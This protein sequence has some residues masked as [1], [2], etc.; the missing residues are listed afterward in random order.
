[1]PRERDPTSRSLGKGP[2]TRTDLLK[3][4]R[5]LQLPKPKWAPGKSIAAAL[6][7][8]KTTREIS[9][10]SLGAQ[11]LS[12]VLF[13]A[14]GV[15][16][17][18]GPFGSRGIT[19]ASASNSQEIDVYVALR[20]G[21]YL[22]DA[23]RH[24]LALVV[25]EDVRSLALGPRQPPISPHAP[26][27]LIFVVDIDK[28][29]HTSGFEE[30]GLHDPEIQKSYYFVDTGIIAGNVYLVA[31]AQGLACWFHNCDRVSLAQKLTLRASQRVL[32]AQTVGYPAAK[33]RGR[34][35]R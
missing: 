3:D 19:A 35:P 6:R 34:R 17:T 20:E 11:L 1:M 9:E 31:A 18:N 15:N 12:N 24:E 21:A 5:A 22:F 8:R 4:R 10:R 13:A 32:F 26:V 7:S 16:R 33:S 29:E 28:L 30:P 14:C 27:Q 25:R 2:K 23:R